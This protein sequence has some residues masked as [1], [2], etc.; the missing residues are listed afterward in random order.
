MMPSKCFD[1]YHNIINKQIAVVNSYSGWRITT[2]AE[3]KKV[4]EKSVKRASK[5]W[6][7][8]LTG[9]AGQAGR[10]NIIAVLFP[11]Y[12]S[13]VVKHSL[14]ALKLMYLCRGY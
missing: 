5:D 12:L 10:G 14:S 2:L 11:G 1:A 6:L 3:V 7:A 13:A 8:V 4:F 9:F